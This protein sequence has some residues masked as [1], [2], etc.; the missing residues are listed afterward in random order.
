[1]CITPGCPSAPLY[2][3]FPLIRRMMRLHD[4]GAIFSVQSIYFVWSAAKRRMESDNRKKAKTVTMSIPH[5]WLAGRH[6]AVNLFNETWR[7]T[8]TK[9]GGSDANVN[10]K[11]KV[12]RMQ[13][14]IKTREPQRKHVV[15]PILLQRDILRCLYGAQ[16]SSAWPRTWG[17]RKFPTTVRYPP[18]RKRRYTIDTWGQ[19]SVSTI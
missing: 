8:K 4:N 6:T 11:R 17:F 13:N 12:G 15:L 7:T 2:A 1:M 10:R 9:Q 5:Y 16:M 19:F 3:F 18:L 14:A